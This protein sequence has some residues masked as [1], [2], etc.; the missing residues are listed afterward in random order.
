MENLLVMVPQ[1]T[2]ATS[3]Y[4]AIGPLAELRRV[5]KD[6]ALTFVQEINWATLDLNDAI[7]M[8]RPYSDSQLKI[9]DL[10]HQNKVPIWLDY[11]DDLFSVPEWN[12][13]YAT[14]SKESI[15][16][17]IATMCAMA[18]VISVSTPAL[19]AKLD[20]LNVDVR[21]VPNAFNERLFG[22]RPEYP[23]PEERTLIFWRGSKTHRRDLTIIAEACISLSQCHP[24]M[25]WFFLG[26]APWFADYMTHS[27]VRC[28]EPI[29]P[30]EYIELLRKIRPTIM[31]VPLDDCEFNR[32]KS[33]I[34]WIEGSFA[35]A[36][37]I[38]PAWSEWLRP[39]VLNYAR[40]AFE[41]QLS[42]AINNRPN[43][44]QSNTESW[45]YISECLS[46]TYVNGL[47]AKI[48]EDLGL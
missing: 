22:H 9:C 15:Q 3:F 5:K 7:F 28:A 26:D 40:G 46:L 37:T 31:L 43:L 21:V 25:T 47:R 39:G 24:E 10:A 17:N 12:P 32:S 8:Q 2:D 27:S 1:T 18:S 16:K 48:L 33:N 44:W 19:K 20:P 6:L 45:Q 23:D 13:C 14:Y 29:D 38:A 34:A 30:I 11:D 42:D 35:G 41:R 36:T 4:R